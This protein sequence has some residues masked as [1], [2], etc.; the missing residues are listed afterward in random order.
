M[1]DRENPEDLEPAGRGDGSRGDGDNHPGQGRVA[2]RGGINDDPEE[3]G[4]EDEER[5]DAG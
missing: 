1:A 2:R 3:Q 4:D 5:F